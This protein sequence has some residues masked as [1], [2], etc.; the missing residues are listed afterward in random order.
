M[1]ELYERSS[2]TFQRSQDFKFDNNLWARFRKTPDELKERLN[3]F[4]QIII[5]RHPLIRLISAYNDK[6]QSKTPGYNPGNARLVVESV[7]GISLPEGAKPD[8][9]FIEFMQFLTDD[10]FAAINDN[11]H[12]KPIFETNQPC[13]CYFDF[14]GHMETLNEDV[15]YLFEILQINDIVSL[16]HKNSS[17]NANLSML[18]EYYMPLPDELFQKVVRKYEN[19]FKVFG[20][21]LPIDAN[22]LAEI[23]DIK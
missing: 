11:T 2:K 22:D 1:Q 10:R 4:T 5:V 13:D 23:Y 17:K 21:R 9:K 15:E 6:L 19:D 12:W 14:I 8:V 18:R 16:P 7:Q 20:Y 3:N